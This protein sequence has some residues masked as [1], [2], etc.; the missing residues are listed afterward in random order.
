MGIYKGKAGHNWGCVWK[1][2]I[3]CMAEQ[4]QPWAPRDWP[5]V[6]AQ[7]CELMGIVSI[8]S[9]SDGRFKNTAYSGWNNWKYHFS[10]VTSTPRE[11]IAAVPSPARSVQHPSRTSLTLQSEPYALRTG[12]SK[13]DEKMA[14]TSGEKASPEPHLRPHSGLRGQAV[15]PGGKGA[16]PDTCPPGQ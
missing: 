9:A 4:H 15:L 11:T 13:G 3:L 6:P 8:S 10:S 16:G 7:C 1:M 12:E 2:W 5:W 14:L